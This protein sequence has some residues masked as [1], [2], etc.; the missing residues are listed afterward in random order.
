MNEVPLYGGVASSL[1]VL[2]DSGL[3]GLGG[4]PRQQK[5]LKGHLPRVIYHRVDF[6]LQ[7]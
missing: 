6:S 4:V 2:I 7:R 1:K 5:T 3:V